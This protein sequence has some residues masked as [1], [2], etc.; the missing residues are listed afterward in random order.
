MADSRRE[1]DA[2][3]AR[4]SLTLAPARDPTHPGFRRAV[5]S[6]AFPFVH[7]APH[8]PVGAEGLEQRHEQN[9]SMLRFR[10]RHDP[11]PSRDYRVFA[12][13]RERSPEVK[14][15]IYKLCKFLVVRQSPRGEACLLSAPAVATSGAR[16]SRRS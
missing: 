9:R 16:G 6:P 4:S 13:D 2:E 5:S 14:S 15:S 3:S 12:A 7:L 11:I 10:G 1:P 8:S